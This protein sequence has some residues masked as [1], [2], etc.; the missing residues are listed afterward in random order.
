[1]FLQKCSDYAILAIIP[2]AVWSLVLN[3]LLYFPNGDTTYATNSQL[4]NYIWYF[5]GI[6][7]GGIMMVLIATVLLLVDFYKC[8]ASCCPSRK[9]CRVNC[10]KLGSMMFA[11]LGVLFS[12]YSLIISSLGI[13][14]G[15]YCRTSTGWQYPFA[16]SMGGYISDSSM[17]TKCLEPAY[18]VEWNLILF[19][20]Q[21]ALSAL[22][23]I[24][25]FCKT[26]CD[27][28]DAFCGTHRILSQRTGTFRSPLEKNSDMAT[29]SYKG[30]IRGH[31]IPSAKYWLIVK[32]KIQAIDTTITNAHEFIRIN[33]L[34]VCSTVRTV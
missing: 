19:S 23:I 29:Y 12:S 25:C 34:Y 13:S 15:P 18:V 6:C 30:L 2:L 9:T 5:S 22:Q 20:I 3:I 4:T 27:I 1:M 10:S 32:C 31:F 33:K 11:F 8:S 17:W 28:R 14:Q 24:I 7:F 26:I 16:S 21:I